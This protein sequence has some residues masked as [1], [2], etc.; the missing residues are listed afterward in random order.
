MFDTP[1]DL[2]FD[3]AGNLFIAD[4]ENAAIRKITQSGTI[5]TVT[6]LLLEPAPVRYDANTT[7]DNG[8]PGTN[9][10][11]GSGGG[12]AL[13]AL[14]LLALAALAVLR[15]RATHRRGAWACSQ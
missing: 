4:T 9:G 1:S 7:G 6:T 8:N 3:S 14:H 15:S 13:S 5:G 10:N 11:S 2:V 12:G